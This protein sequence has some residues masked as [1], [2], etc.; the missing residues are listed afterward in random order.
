[1]GVGVARRSFQFLAVGVGLA[2]PQ[3]L[4]DGAVEQIGVLMNDGD[5]PAHRLGI[6]R[7][8]IAPAD[9]NFA[10]LRVEQAQQQ[11]RDRGFSRSARADDA[12]LLA[13]GDGKGEPVMGGAAAAGIGE[14]NIFKS[15][16]GH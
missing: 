13:R 14:M 11:A 9:Q 6:E 8:Q 12:D 15:D 4:F 16:R 7:L 5:H 10:S 1:M 2:E 3:V